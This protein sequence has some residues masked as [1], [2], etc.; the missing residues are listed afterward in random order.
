MPAPDA[1]AGLGHDPAHVRQGPGVGGPPRGRGREEPVHRGAGVE[2][3]RHLSGRGAEAPPVPRQHVEHRYVGREEPRPVHDRQ[4]LV[5]REHLTGAAQSPLQADRRHLAEPQ[6]AVEVYRVVHTDPPH[7]LVRVVVGHLVVGDVG[8]HLRAVDGG[9]AQRRGGEDER[10]AQRRLPRQNRGDRARD[11]E[12]AADQRGDE[13]DESRPE[14][15]TTYDTRASQGARSIT[16]PPGTV[17][18]RESSRPACPP[19]APR[20]PRR[21]GRASGRRGRGSRAPAPPCAA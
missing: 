5:V 10:D 7:Q 13:A 2:H 12:P 6:R 17:H 14:R 19:R 9:V 21:S 20:P 18:A 4:Q 16:A 1:L 8:P 3:G 11:G 15:K